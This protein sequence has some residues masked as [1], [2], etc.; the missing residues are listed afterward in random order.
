M[1]VGSAV[2]AIDSRKIVGN[3]YGLYIAEKAITDQSRYDT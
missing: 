3:P 2:N 1:L